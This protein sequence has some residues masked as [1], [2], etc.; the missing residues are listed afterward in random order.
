MDS[1]TPHL[2]N[3]TRDWVNGAR[4][5]DIAR[6]YFSRGADRLETEAF[7]DVKLFTVLSSIMVHGVYRP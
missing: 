2:S 4:L 3:I 7:T 6:T 1:T 5:D